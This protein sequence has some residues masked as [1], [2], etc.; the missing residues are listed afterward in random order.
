ME[1]YVVYEIKGDTPTP[2]HD[3]PLSEIEA[4]ELQSKHEN[5]YSHPAY[6]ITLREWFVQYVK[7]Y[8]TSD[9]QIRMWL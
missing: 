8:C 7:P 2:I 4:V 3:N 5:R 6:I 1:N 9:H